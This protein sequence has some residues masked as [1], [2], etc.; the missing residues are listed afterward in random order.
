MHLDDAI[1]RV[2]GPLTRGHAA[3]Y[4]ATGGRV[5]AHFRGAPSLLVLEHV[6]A[7]TGKLR[8]NPLVYMPDG[9]NL[10]IV[11]SKG[12]AHSNPAWLHNLRA[13]PEATVYID[14]KSVSVR[15]HELTQEE[16]DRMWPRAASFNPHWEGYQKRT[17]RQIPL[18]LLEPQEQA[19]RPTSVSPRT[20]QS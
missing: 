8:R 5:G 14:D 2:M 19:D 20:D 16:R 9:E 17:S 15:A 18:V 1:W 12:G 6:G 7:K 11:A 13:H 4:R 3:I 10:L